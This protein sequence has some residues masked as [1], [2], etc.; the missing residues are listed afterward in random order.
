MKTILI[1]GSARRNGDTTKISTLLQEETH[2]DALN[3]SDYTISHYDYEHKNAGDDFLPLIEKI[4]HQYDRFIFATPVYWYS[5]SGIMKVFFDRLSDL[6]TIRKDL[7]RALKGKQ[8]AVISSSAG[9][10]LGEQFWL[11]FSRSAEYLEMV[12]IQGLHTELID[13][14]ISSKEKAR[15]LSFVETVQNFKVL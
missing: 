1:I 9:D 4:V 13:D 8:M 2:W 6:V 15:I 14:K 3:L 11:P 7:G 10:N 12:F 5:M